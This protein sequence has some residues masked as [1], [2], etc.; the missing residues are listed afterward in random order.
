MA[1]KMAIRDTPESEYVYRCCFC[2]SEADLSFKTATLMRLDCVKHGSTLHQRW[3]KRP[4]GVMEPAE[5]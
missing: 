3:I 4:D 1:L 2:H 5:A